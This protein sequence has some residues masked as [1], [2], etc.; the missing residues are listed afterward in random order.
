MKLPCNVIEDLLPMYYDRV[1]SAESVALVEEHLK[2][3]PHCRSILSELRA[4]LP[5]PEKNVD[6][7][8]PLKKLQKSYR[9][10]KTYWLVATLAVLLLIPFAF[11]VGTWQSGQNGMPV[12]FSKEEAIAYANEFMTCLEERDYE[13]AF[14]YYNLA[15]KKRDLL[16]GNLFTADDLVNFEADGLKKFC[17]G[18]KKLET[19]G[20]ITDV[21]F[22]K[23]SEAS[24]SNR[25]G[26][27]EYFVSFSFQFDGRQEKFGINLTKDGIEFISYG[28]GRINHP[29]SHLT[30]WV[31]WVVDDYKGQSYDFDSG[32]WVNRSEEP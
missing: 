25:Y 8:K 17:E 9:K 26:T 18:G 19:W 20:G 21:Q 6:D 10:K 23:I 32:K 4:D 7:S 29:L 11:L 14:T 2:A 15:E 13:K 22:E 3:C 30:L 5:T 28:D 1:C 27:E 24:Y 31:Q 12:E 16:S